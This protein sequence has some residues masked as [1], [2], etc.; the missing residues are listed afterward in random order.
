MD[1]TIISDT[2]TRNLNIVTPSVR[3]DECV[4]QGL[5]ISRSQAQELIKQ[6][7]V[8]N[9]GIKSQKSG[10]KLTKDTILHITLPVQDSKP[11]APKISPLEI[12]R[13]YE[14]EELLILNKP[15]NLIVH[16]APSVKEETLVDW[17]QAQGVML[18]TLSGTHRAGIVHRL[19]KQTSGAI[20]IAKTNATHAYLSQELKDRRMG[21][22]YLAL[23]DKPIKESRMIT[24]NLARHPN[25]RLK[26]T[27]ID[28]MGLRVSSARFSQSAFIPL[29]NTQE[30]SLLAIKL[31]TGRT[32]QIRAHLESINRHILG[33]RLYGYA[34]TLGCRVQLHAYL[35]Y[36]AHPITRKQMVFR[37][38]IFGDMLQCAQIFGAKEF[39]EAIRQDAIVQAFNQWDTAYRAK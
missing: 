2:S 4:A 16:S 26:M 28:A 5:H 27:N 14:D 35:L 37:A 24:C 19:D 9:N 29:I 1:I 13:I 10:L 39:D 38:E 33:D 3:L 20:A 23:I 12:A 31:Y 8:Q 6:G 17:L 32:H 25:N 18:S 34:G 7:Y 30:T 15:P 11:S 22:Y 21:R 36:L